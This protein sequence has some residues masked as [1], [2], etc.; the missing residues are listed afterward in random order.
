LDRLNAGAESCHF[1]EVADHFR[2]KALA[3]MMD[4]VLEVR[5]EDEIKKDILKPKCMVSFSHIC[6]ISVLLTHGVLLFALLCN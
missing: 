4:G 5:W 1:T 2:E 3:A 6:L